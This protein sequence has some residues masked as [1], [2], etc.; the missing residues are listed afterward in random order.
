MQHHLI[1][2]EVKI[3]RHLLLGLKLIASSSLYC[4]SS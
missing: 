1:N 2:T 4:W 3:V